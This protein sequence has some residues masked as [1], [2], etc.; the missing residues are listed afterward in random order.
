MRHLAESGAD[1]RAGVRAG[2]PRSGRS[3]RRPNRVRR[4][5]ARRPR[6]RSTPPGRF[7]A[8]IE[9]CGLP[10]PTCMRPTSRGGAA[11]HRSR[12]ATRDRSARLPLRLRRPASGR[13]ARARRPRARPA[14]RIARHRAP[15]RC[16]GRS[17]GRRVRPGWSRS[18]RPA[19]TPTTDRRIASAS[20]RWPWSCSFR[21]S[22]HA[23][24]T[25]TRDLPRALR[26]SSTTGR[27]RTST[28]GA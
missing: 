10:W 13:R 24:R 8:S 28:V 25:A 12:V 20:D 17:P 6:R 16:R 4:A 19:M 23:A 7:S 15:P 18:P 3:P 5:A 27:A 9:P 14:H 1:R 21:S 2:R 26:P 22:R 11:R